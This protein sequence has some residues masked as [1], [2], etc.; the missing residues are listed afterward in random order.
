MVP[1]LMLIFYFA[2]HEQKNNY[3]RWIIT[4]LIFSLMGDV[5]LL[6]STD[7]EQAFMT[8]LASFLLAQ[9]SYFIG[10]LLAARHPKGPFILWRHPWLLPVLLGYGILLLWQIF[11]GLEDMLVPVIIY[12]G[13][14]LLMVLAALHLGLKRKTWGLPIGALLFL[15]SDSILAVNQF[16]ELL[17]DINA[18]FFVMLLY[19]FAQ[20]MIVEGMLRMNGSVRN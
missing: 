14:L 10:F 11:P 6:F 5:F 3:N 12:A 16:T 7:F 17:Q 1:V 9:I 4:A 2:T 18:N 20:W 15:F 13:C 19:G 8:G